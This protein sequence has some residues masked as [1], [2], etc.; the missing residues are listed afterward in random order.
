MKQVKNQ[1]DARIDKLR[2]FAGVNPQEDWYSRGE[3]DIL[4]AFLN[5]TFEDLE[6]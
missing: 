3:L 4:E 2:N 5:I 6:D 1:F